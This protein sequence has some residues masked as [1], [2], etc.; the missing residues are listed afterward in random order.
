M[1]GQL[2]QI[3]KRA[4]EPAVNNSATASSPTPNAGISNQMLQGRV[5]AGNGQST[6]SSDPPA[7]TG[8]EWIVDDTATT[9][10]AGQM[11]KSDFLAALKAGVCQ[12]AADALAGTQWSEKG[13][14]FIEHWFG[15][16]AFQDAA[17]VER[18]AQKYALVS[19]SAANA[20]D[21]I[22]PILDRVHRATAIWV[23]TGQVTGAPEGVP[24]LPPGTGAEGA[25]PASPTA[26][27]SPSD[28]SGPARVQAKARDGMVPK[29]G[30]P[31]AIQAKLGAGMPLQS[32][33]RSSVG[34]V[35]GQDFSDTRV[36]LDA[37][38]GRLSSDLHARAFTVGRHIAFAPGEYRP[39]T[40]I[41]DALIAHEL[42]HVAQQNGGNPLEPALHAKDG[43]ADAPLERE[44]DLAAAGAMQTMYGRAQEQ[45]LLPTVRP[46]MGRGLRLSR[47]SASEKV[48]TNL[49]TVQAKAEWIRNALQGSTSTFEPPPGIFFRRTKGEA[50]VDMLATL[51]SAEFI[52]IQSQISMSDLLDELTDF[53]TVR[54]GTLGPLQAEVRDRVNHTRAD[55]LEQMTH[56]R[57][58]SEAEVVAHWLFNNMYGN[59]IQDVLRLLGEDQQL[60]D[61]VDKMPA[62]LELIQQRGVD[63]QK[64]QDRSWRVRDIGT[65]LLN[66]GKSVLGS[67][68]LAK[69]STGQK[70]LSSDM[71]LPPEYQGAMSDVMSAELDEALKPG[72]LILGSLDYLAFNIPSSAVGVVSGTVS[73]IKDLSQ[74]H[75][76]AG[77]EKLTGSVIFIVGIALG[78][79]AFRK[80]A[81]M[82]ALLE[83]TPEGEAA[84]ARLRASI[85][86]AGIDR[87]AKYAQA[88]SNAA[89]LVREQGLAGIEALEK[90]AGNV[91]AARTLLGADV[92]RLGSLLTT[93]TLAGLDLATQQ[94]LSTL[95]D[96]T[97]RG[98]AGADAATLD[99]MAQML[100][101]T[102]P[103]MRARLITLA[104]SNP[105]GFG[106]LLRTQKIAV[107]DALRS[108]PF[109]T[110]DALAKAVGDTAGRVR[111]PVVKNGVTLYESIDPAKPPPGWK[112]K[113]TVTRRGGS[114]T[115]RTDVTDPNG[116]TGYFVRRLNV[117]TGELQM[118]EAFLRSSQAA[119]EI[120]NAVPS[121]V[122]L[123]T[124][125][126]TST[127][128]YATL[129]QLRTQG[130]EMGSLRRIVMRD[131]E[132]FR[133]ICRLEWMRRNF[134]TR[135]LNQ[136]VMDTDSVSYASTAAEQSGSR[137][138]GG[139]LTGGRVQPIGNL[140]GRYL[141]EAAEGG[142]ETVQRVRAEQDAILQ[143]YG[144]DRQTPMLTNF[145]IE[146]SLE[147]IPPQ[148]PAPAPGTSTP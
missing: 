42:A 126:G 82:A 110:V 62:V 123:K 132:N 105:A 58:P 125:K 84:V 108:G 86:Q 24:M 2:E 80:G 68:P 29:S 93:D 98:M 23:A 8:H 114:V 74:G 55:Y 100:R 75:V 94:A 124:G 95:P 61:T 45:A 117:A 85:G 11:K 88:D 9:L 49:T 35:F 25:T 60:Y 129:R 17:H 71:E 72:N 142:A 103:A 121:E 91:A 19:A 64:F 141:H 135:S 102:S 147:P 7:P 39:G 73:G 1:S 34:A 66:F 128:A 40:P 106:E 89:F 87:V 101:E 146:L 70:Y 4:P 44:A 21:Y 134:P 139:Q 115:I 90:A 65:G 69:D 119:P 41:G 27:D 12:T 116:N 104:E 107:L 5:T 48:P 38:A 52:D 67:S 130:V 83:M 76:A 22:A 51:P 14:P 140:M 47:C 131:I 53:E 118:L 31:R 20:R 111:V 46:A 145:D 33:L 79:R 37:T 109:S 77:T 36:H 120:K 15:Y 3:P 32:H 112:F 16:Y 133:S 136:L 54:L 97:L 81:R 78:V 57:G 144:F 96:A 59:D 30:D 92:T 99:A 148:G 143:R 50:I 63:R 122:E 10:D 138:V 13:C 26:S 6:A 137:V 127:V 56:D 43:E 28:S 18:A 113:D